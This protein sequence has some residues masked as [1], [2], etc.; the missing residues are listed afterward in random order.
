MGLPFERYSRTFYF[1]LCDFVIDRL[2]ADD[3]D[4]FDF[5]CNLNPEVSDDEFVTTAKNLNVFLVPWWTI[6]ELWDNCFGPDSRFVVE[7]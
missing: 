2:L 3:K 1:A 5:G 6:K 7:L 4:Y